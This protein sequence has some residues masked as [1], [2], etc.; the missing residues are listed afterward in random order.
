MFRSRW[1]YVLSLALTSTSS[2]QHFTFQDSTFA[3][4]DTMRRHDVFFDL[5]H[6]WLRSESA[7]VIDSLIQFMASHP[8]FSMEV[9]MHTD[10]R[11]GI[12]FNLHLT[13]CRANE[14]L[15]YMTNRG[16]DSTRLSAVGFGQSRPLN[17][18]ANGVP[19]SDLQ[20]RLNRRTEFV[21]TAIDTSQ[22]ALRQVAAD[23]ASVTRVHCEDPSIY[24]AGFMTVQKEPVRAE[25]RMLK[26]SLLLP[27]AH[28]LPDWTLYLIYERTQYNSGIR[29]ANSIGFSGSSKP[30]M[31]DLTNVPDGNYFLRY[32]TST[33]W[34]LWENTLEIAT[35]DQ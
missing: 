17:Q 8:D 33:G 19:C 29:A 1:L 5:D 4:G 10:A 18:C 26:D 7:T 30:G 20:H 34:A 28:F 27:V 6:C 22:P 3:V 25:R 23:A 31:M 12:E 16:V 32:R 2:A 24:S 9:G 35:T 15:E 14:V 13:L 21:I 11:G